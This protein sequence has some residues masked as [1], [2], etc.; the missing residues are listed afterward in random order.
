M[1][2]GNFS[3]EEDLFLYLKNTKYINNWDL[4]D[5]SAP[6]IVG[7]FLLDKDKKILYELAESENLCYWQPGYYR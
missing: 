3:L 2:S 1:F 4:V 7:D 6:K 5:L